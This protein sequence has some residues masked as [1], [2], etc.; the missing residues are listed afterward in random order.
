M[1]PMTY[2]LLTGIYQ[3]LACLGFMAVLLFA[4]WVTKKVLR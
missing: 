2:D 4:A 1:I 3:A